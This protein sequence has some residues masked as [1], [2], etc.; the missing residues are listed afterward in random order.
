LTRRPYIHPT[1]IGTY[2]V[3]PAAHPG[4]GPPGWP[5]SP[6]LPPPIVL[7]DG[8]RLPIPWPRNLHNSCA[9]RHTPV[10]TVSVWHPG[11]IKC[12]PVREP[13]APVRV[14]RQEVAQ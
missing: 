8:L 11:R 10:D 3:T 5:T 7:A 12:Q 13:L 6:H 14:A 2:R 4:A 9:H 1:R